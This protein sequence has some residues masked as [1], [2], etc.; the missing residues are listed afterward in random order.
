MNIKNTPSQWCVPFL[1][2]AYTLYTKRTKLKNPKKEKRMWRKNQCRECVD[3]VLYLQ[4]LVSLPVCHEL[5]HW[6]L[7]AVRDLTRGGRLSTYDENVLNL[8][9]VS[10]LEKCARMGHPLKL[11][12]PTKLAWLGHFPPASQAGPLP[13]GL[14]GSVFCISFLCLRLIEGVRVGGRGRMVK[15][16]FPWKRKEC[17]KIKNKIAKKFLASLPGKKTKTVIDPNLIDCFK[18]LFELYLSLLFCYQLYLY[19]WAFWIVCG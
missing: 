5:L 15:V 19:L 6:P 18:S 17:G 7:P 10:F 1:V 12:S 8:S 13:S 14:A 4:E 3:L 2:D 9:K 11:P 16:G